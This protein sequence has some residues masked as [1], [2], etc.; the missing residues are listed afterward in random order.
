MYDPQL[1]GDGKQKWFTL[2]DLRFEIVW[3]CF[4]YMLS[5]YNHDSPGGIDTMDT[6]Q[7]NHLTFSSTL[8]LYAK[9]TTWVLKTFKR[10]KFKI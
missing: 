8:I 7:I 3:I 5:F 2:Y 4:N 9:I 6:V 1:I 10:T